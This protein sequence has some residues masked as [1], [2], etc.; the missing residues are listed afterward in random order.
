MSTNEKNKEFKKLFEE[1]DKKGY[2]AKSYRWIH[3]GE[4]Y[5]SL[6][7]REVEA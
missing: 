4:G 6:E 1:I 5:E 3:K 7:K 2:R